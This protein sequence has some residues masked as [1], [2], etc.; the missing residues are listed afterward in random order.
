MI[1]KCSAGHITDTSK[2]SLSGPDPKFKKPGDRCGQLI[3]YNVMQ[4]STF[5][6]RILKDVDNPTLTTSQLR[7]L[8]LIQTAPG[9]Y[10]APRQFA[11]LMWPDSE[12]W[13]R[14]SKAGPYGSAKG[15]GMNLA[16]GGYLGKLTRKG[17][18]VKIYDKYDNPTYRLSKEGKKCLAKVNKYLFFRGSVG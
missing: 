14:R 4:G 1:L 8:R 18:L 10:V 11:K 15:G 12:G 7:A 16:A 9:G 3:S 17:L 2:S 5:C 13:R 6:Q